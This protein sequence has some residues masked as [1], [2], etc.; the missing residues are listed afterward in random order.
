MNPTPTKHHKPD[1][2]GL[3]KDIEAPP[4]PHGRRRPHGAHLRRNRPARSAG[5]LR[6]PRRQRRRQDPR[7][8]KRPPATR[9]TSRRSASSTSPPSTSTRC[10]RSP[11]SSSRSPRSRAAPCSTGP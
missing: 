10:R 11:G 9:A 4:R 6:R 8:G 5:R 3:T 2:T 1:T 7:G